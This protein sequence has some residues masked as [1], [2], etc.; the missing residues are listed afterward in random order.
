M[1]FYVRIAAMLLLMIIGDTTF[2]QEVCDCV[3][4]GNCPVPITDNGTYQGTLDV[5]A[6]GANDL[7]TCPLTS[8]C[9]TITHTWIG[10]LSVSLTSPSGVNYLLMAD[11][12]NNYGGCGMQQDNAEVCIVLGDNNP[13]TDSTEYIC[14]AGACAAGVCCLTGNWTVPCGGVTDPING[15]LQA[16]NCD[17]NDFNVPGDPANGTWTLTVVDVCNM[18]TGTLDN[19]SLTFACGVE[20]CIVCSADGGLLDSIEVTSCFGDPDLLLDLEPNYSGV[21]PDTTYGYGYIVSQNGV[22][23]EIDSVADLTTQPPGTY[24]VYGFSYVLFDSLEING[25]IGLDT[26]TVISQLASTTAPFC[27]NLSDNY[28]P[29]NILPA[30]PITVVDT[31]VC[32]GDCIL[33]GNQ[34]VCSSTTVTLSSYLGCDSIIDVNLTLIIPDTVAFATVVC[35]G[36]CIDIGDNQYCPPGPYSVTLTNALGCDSVVN[37]TF[38]EIVTNAV[39]SPANPPV[40]TCSNSSTVLDGSGSVGNGFDWIGPNGF[41]SD[42]PSVTVTEPGDYTLT[43]FDNTVSPACQA[44]TTVTVGN[45]FIFPDLIVVGAAP[46]ICGGT[47]F[48][49]ASLTVQDQNNTNPTITYHS[50]TPATS[51]NELSSTIVNPV[52]T[53]AYYILGVNGACTDETS[54]VLTVNSTPTA[55]FTATATI[56]ATDEATVTYSGTATAGAIFNWDFDG[57]VAVPGTGAGPHLVSWNSGGIHSITLTVEQNGCSSTVFTQDVMVEMPLAVPQITCISTTSTIT[58]SWDDVPGSTGFNVT[59]LSSPPFNNGMSGAAPNTYV[60]TDLDAGQSATIRVVAVGAG[61]CGNSSSQATCYAEDCPNDVVI[62]IVPV[63]DICLNDATLPTILSVSVSGGL[64]NGTFVWSGQGVTISGNFDPELGSL[65]TNTLR[66]DYYEENCVFTETIDIDVYETPLVAIDVPYNI[67]SGFPVPINFA[68]IAEPGS[69]YTWDFEGGTVVSGSGPGPINVL[70]PAGGSYDVSL[71]VE[72]PY[73]C[74][75]ETLVEAVTLATPLAPPDITCSSNTSGVVFSWTPD[76]NASSYSVTFPSGHTGIKLTNTSYEVTNLPPGEIVTIQV[77]VVGAVSCGNSSFSTSCEVEACP[78]VQMTIDPVN[79]ICLTTSTVPFN[80][81]ATVTGDTPNGILTWIGNGVNDVGLF[82]PSQADLGANTISLTYE[83]NTCFFVETITINVFETPT[84]DFT[85]DA[86]ICTG[87]AATVTYTGAN[88][89]NLNY[90]WDFAGGIA[91]STI[92]PGPHNVVWATGGTRTISLVVENAGGCISEMATMDVFVEDPIQMPTVICSATTTTSIEFSWNNVLGVVSSDI[93]VSVP[94]M[95]VLQGNTYTLTGLPPSTPVDFE[96]TLMGAGACPSVIATASCSTDNCP[97]ITSDPILPYDFCL[98]VSNPTPLTIGII[99]SDGSGIGLWSGNGVDVNSGMFDPVQAGAGAHVVT[100]TFIEHQCT[101]EFFIPVNVFQQPSSSFT[102]DDIVCIVDGATVTF[103]GTASNNADYIW[104]FDG[105]TAVPGT[106]PGPH[107]VIWDTPGDRTVTLDIQDNGC[108]AGQFTQQV[109]VDEALTAP[110][111]SCTATTESVTFTWTDV[112]GALS[113]QV[114]LPNQGPDVQTVMN[115]TYFVDGL[116][117]GEEVIL[118]IIPI[119]N[120]VCPPPVTNAAC[121]ANLCSDVIVQ[122]LPVDPICFVPD[123]GQVTLQATVTGAGSGIGTWSGTGVVDPV[124]GIFDPLIAGEGVHTIAYDLQLVNCFYTNEIEIKIAPPPTADAGEDASLTCW[125]SESSVRLGGDSTST[126]PNVIF[127]WTTVS[128][129]LPDNTTILRPEVSEPG[130]YLLTVTD[131]ELGC[132]SSDE[133]IV[134]SLIGLPESNVSFSSSDCSGQNTTVTVDNVSGGLEPYFFSL[135]GEPYVAEDTFAFLSTGIYT[136]SIIDAAGCESDTV[137]EIQNYGSEMS[138]DLTAN[139]VGRNHIE[140]GESIQLLALL[141]IPFGD[142]DSIVWSNPEL[143]SC[144]DCLDPMATPTEATTF[145]V[146]A[147][148]DGCEV[149]DELIIHV[150][151]KNPVFV[152]NAFSP[153]DDNVNDL[154]QIFAG[155]RVTNINSFMIFDRWGEMVFSQKDFLPNDPTIGWDGTLRGKVMQPAVFAWFAEIELI[156]GST[157]IIEGEVALIR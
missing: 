81:T 89:T 98:G 86:A 5:I 90:T 13:L 114:A 100:Y 58:F 47:P 104:D 132:S 66:V 27:G 4:T 48:D 2:A 112:P 42:Q 129:E 31:A 107:Q 50:G 131:V 60:F 92:G 91:D 103:N 11:V 96:L 134:S 102:T 73:G 21:P 154:F 20:T 128:G 80:L 118:Q 43:V 61:L 142:L 51:A 113:Y 146:T 44:S 143:L 82:D 77:Q 85:S 70:W 15:A 106:G 37:L 139:L 78:D 79:D 63:P 41:T 34:Q 109:Q 144:T 137:F 75:S 108:I 99:G 22:V 83:E 8:V 124:A 120:T 18:D 71:S 148:R 110:M 55:D 56:C 155:D 101:F 64:G 122:V 147:Y 46:Q 54:V 97:D 35:E 36:D 26:A 53:T 121:N 12:N 39:I 68:G 52:A 152:P 40:L 115:T 116:D 19:F 33:V 94:Q 111:V 125:E 130:T 67:C 133:V 7:G 10:D 72:S 6:S 49:L 119:G 38:T 105:G 135:N 3:T 87:D 138:I 30:I 93:S 74:I 145:T 59:V 151:Y 29:V 149:T 14:N 24:H 17:L 153:N 28:I 88:N 126:G 140:E 95:G 25:M 16:P 84:A 65:G 32:E 136:L 45:G 150:E 69:I 156:D 117:P 9:F 127:E 141:N 62:T 57:G 76:P 23:L 123:A 1:A 157:E